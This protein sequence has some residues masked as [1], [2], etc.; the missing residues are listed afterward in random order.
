MWIF[1]DVVVG[2]IKAFHK[3]SLSFVIFLINKEVVEVD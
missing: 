2:R 1:T 3:F